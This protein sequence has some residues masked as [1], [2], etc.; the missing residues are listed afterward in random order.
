M[1]DLRREVH[2]LLA[3][4]PTTRG[5]GFAVL[6]G[7]ARLIDWGTKDSGRADSHAVQR[8]ITALLDRYLPDALVVEDVTHRDSRRCTRIREL[9]DSL[10][11]EGE[12]RGVSVITVSRDRVRSVFGGAVA[13]NKH[14]VAEIICGHFPE[15]VPRLPPRRKPWM[16]EDARSSIFDAVSFALVYYFEN[17]EAEA[18]A[19]G[20][21]TQPE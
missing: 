10:R 11:D 3:V 4:D 16:S 13:S 21:S 2:R 6:E 12:R 15:L 1:E 19:R 20:V 5:F 17:T 9:V 18:G 14:A 8:E 7:A